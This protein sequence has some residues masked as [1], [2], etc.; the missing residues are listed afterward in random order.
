[1]KEPGNQVGS[2]FTKKWEY[3]LLKY[4]ESKESSDERTRFAC[5]TGGIL[6]NSGVESGSLQFSL[7]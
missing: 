3:N 7:E 2:I 6:Q 4:D 5:I 1:M